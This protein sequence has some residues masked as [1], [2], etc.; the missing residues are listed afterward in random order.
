MRSMVEGAE[1]GSA[2]GLPPPPLRGPPPP[3]LRD[4][5]GLKA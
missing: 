5:G 1:A 3:S 4:K 2:W